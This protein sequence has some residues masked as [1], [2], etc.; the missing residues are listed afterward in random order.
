MSTGWVE[1]EDIRC[2]YH[3]WK[4]DGFGRCLEQPAELDAF[5]SKVAIPGYP[6][7]EYLGLVFAFIGEGEPPPFWRFS[8]LEGEGE[9]VVRSW[10]RNSNYWNGIE[11]SCDQVHVN[12]VHRDSE[13][14]ESGAQ[15]EIPKIDAA[16]TSY[17]I[18]RDVTYSDGGVRTAHTIMPTG[19]LVQVYDEEAGWMPHL[20]YR[21]PI[22]DER[23]LNLTASLARV[24]GDAAERFNRRRRER[25]A[26]IAA[27]PPVED[28]VDRVMRGEL[29]LHDIKRPD[30][31]ALQD[32]VALRAQPA[33][34]VRKPD[35]LG[36]SDIQIIVLR[37]IWAREMRALANGE[38]LKAWDVP[39]DLVATSGS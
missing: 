19:S 26:E 10:S 7:R 33:I 28:V 5:S 17:G 8:Q 14:A 30:I 37:K 38:P 32:A 34:G 24:T 15:R 6:T 29:Y 18:R 21:I 16:E 1:G 31:V 27:L 23:H 39:A 35:R 11:N 36:K 13:L 25:A 22:D 3:G 4:Y 12:F 9:L 20:S 2:F